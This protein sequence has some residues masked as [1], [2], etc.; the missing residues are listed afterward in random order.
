MHKSGG[1]Q[2]FK[3]LAV[4]FVMSPN[5]CC[6]YSI[7]CEDI[8]AAPSLH[9]LSSA[10]VPPGTDGWKR[11]DRVW[12]KGFLNKRTKDL[13]CRSAGHRGSFP[14]KLLAWY[15]A[16]HH[17]DVTTCTSVEDHCIHQPNSFKFS[18][19]QR[20]SSTHDRTCGSP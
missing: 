2:R 18:S 12:L 20:L 10:L 4:I 11:Q 9:S 7:R 6:G 15:K 8:T 5:S 16:W 1:T 14:N 13:F 3:S 17:Q 19:S